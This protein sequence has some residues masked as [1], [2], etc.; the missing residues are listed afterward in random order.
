MWKGYGLIYT[1][2]IYI[3]QAFQNIMVHYGYGYI[4]LIEYIAS[5]HK[6]TA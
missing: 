4:H 5:T 1:Q 2:K 3:D 6:K